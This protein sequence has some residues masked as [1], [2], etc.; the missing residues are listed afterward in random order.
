MECSVGVFCGEECHKG[1][2]GEVSKS[3][4]LI[5]EFSEENSLLLKLRTNEDIK[6]ICKYHELKFLLKYNHLYGRVC[7]DPCKIHL[8]PV[9]KGLREITLSYLSRLKSVDNVVLIP[10]KSMCPTCNTKLFKFDKEDHHEDPPFVPVSESINLIDQACST[11]GISPASKIRKFSTGKRVVAIE[12]KV[13]KIS[14]KLK[15]NLFENFEQNYDSLAKTDQPTTSNSSEH[16]DL[17]T[18]L[19]EKCFVSNKEEKVK[20][21]SL[22]PSSWSRQKIS[23][24]FGVSERLVKLS[25]DLVKTQGVL[26]DLHK[27]DYGRRISSTTIDTV[28][29]FYLSEENSR[30]CPG[31]KDYVS[32]RIEGKSVHKQ[33][34][35]LLSNL[36]ELY[37]KF[38]ENYPDVKIGRSKF[39]ELRPKWCVIAGA[40]GTHT[41]CVCSYHQNIKLMIVGANLNIDYKDL[42]EELTCDINNYKCMMNECDECGDVKGLLETL[43]QSEEIEE[44]PDNIE[45]KQWVTVDRAEMVT[46]QKPRDD[47]F[48]SLVQKAK[49][50]KSHHYVSKVQ[51]TS[52][53]NLKN[54]LTK[55]ECVVIADFSE[56][57][58]FV[59]QDEIQS[60]HWVN[61]QATVHPFVYYYFDDDVGIVKSRSLCIISNHQQH[62]TA[63]V[64]CFQK[65][66]IEDLKAIAPTIKKVIYFTDGASSQ[67]KNKKNFL[68]I[69]YHEQDFGLQVEWHFFATAHGKNACDGIGGTTKREVTKTSLQSTCKNQ[70][71]T[72]KDMFEFCSQN[73]KGI[74][75][76]YVDSEEILQHESQLEVRF[77]TCLKIPG[78]RSFHRIVPI[79]ENKVKCFKTSQATE[80]LE[81]FTTSA[82][83]LSL[84][85]NDVIACVYDG[86]WWLG[87]IQTVSIEHNDFYVHFFEP[88]GPR[89]SFKLSAHD[90]VWVPF[91]KILRK[92]KPTELKTATGRNHNISQDLCDEISQLLNCQNSK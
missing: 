91:H 68:N 83:S 92:I 31:K 13:N 89:T 65:Y 45:Y 60:Y 51:S 37:V 78:T 57:F 59:M 26:P 7:S 1:V 62:N 75:Y 79:S 39:C 72:A 87:V 88:S 4:K 49:D 47:F 9:K 3:I 18:K 55:E 10:G 50:L 25:R 86:K 32:V 84:S 12:K 29:E 6:T 42:L 52:F 35:L 33:K 19:K 58:T 15:R 54:S 71:L 53:K 73:L 41:V 2:Y 61:K 44:M 11:F 64:H 85:E 23:Q 46:I 81:F 80:H 56:N 77:K 24:E 82:I 74:Q 67:Y 17:I 69:C 38:K 16:E 27:K 76:Y 40:S 48:E 28:V 30:I 20:I 5:S 66:F 21:I 8:K 43:L 36:N 14:E 90:E 34:H 22:L 63:V 70:I